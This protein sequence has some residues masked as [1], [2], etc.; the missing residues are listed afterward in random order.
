VTCAIAPG[1]DVLTGD[2]FRL[3]QA[4]ENLTAN[5][6]RHT[7][8]GGSVAL[9]SELIPD[10]ETGAAGI[11]LTVTDSGE[12]IP[13]EELPLIF[14]RFYKAKSGRRDA[15]NGSGLGLSIVKAIVERHGGKVWANS[16][17][18][19]G[20]TIGLELPSARASNPLIH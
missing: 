7:E 19:R 16:A 6:L 11:R 12:G 8:N 13:L 14:D 5:A 4:V 18:G 17:L 15:S 10:E 2:S 3:G 9:K 1:A 20:T